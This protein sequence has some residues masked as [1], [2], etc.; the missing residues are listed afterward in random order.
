MDIS[1]VPIWITSS[2]SAIGVIYAIAR[3]G[4]RARSQDEQLKAEL[5]LEIKGIKIQ[6]DDSENGL[7]AIK[8]STDEMKLHCANVS[9]A[10]SA[11]TKTN[12]D[13]IAILRR[14]KR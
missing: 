6:L 2:A 10:I 4:K 11:Q 3:N 5:K 9:T 1:L 12:A 14:E 13:E 8:K 7:S